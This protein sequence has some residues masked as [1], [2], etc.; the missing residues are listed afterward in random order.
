MKNI[1]N[2]ELDPRDPLSYSKRV[3]IESI[4]YNSNQVW[5]LKNDIYTKIYFA[6]SLVFAIFIS[7]FAE[8]LNWVMVLI[9]VNL[10]LFT[11]ILFAKKFYK[12]RR[13]YFK[14]THQILKKL[15]EQGVKLNHWL[16]TQE[17]LNTQSPF[18]WKYL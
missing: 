7:I 3:N 6:L 9:I 8:K 14:I 16:F 15:K 1:Q 5:I 13:E 18:Y 4:R 17:V 10:L 12:E 11:L 2:V